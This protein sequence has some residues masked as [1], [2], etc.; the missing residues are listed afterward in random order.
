MSQNHLS[1]FFEPQGVVLVG[2]RRSMGF[3]YGIPLYLQKQ[4]WGDRLHLVNPLG[5][6]LHGLSVYKRVQDVPDPVDLAI[7]I[8]P[9]KIVPQ[10]M[11]EIGDRGITHV[12]I[13]TAGFGEIGEAGK[14]LQ[15]N[16]K[17]IA[18]RRG[19]R[20]IGPNCVGVVNTANRFASVELLDESLTPGHLGI[21]AQSGVFGNILLDQIPFYDLSISKAVTLGNRLDVDE[22][23][24]LQYLKSDSLT[25]VIMLYLEG[26]ADGRRFK[27]VLAE[28]T[29]AKPVL[30]LKSGRT[31]IGRQATA[32]HTGSLS[33]EDALYSALFQQTGAVRAQSLSQLIDLARVF[34]SQP[35]PSGNR[36][37]IITTSGSLGA[38]A[39]DMAESGGLIVPP[40]SP[41]TVSKANSVAPE[42]MNVLNPLDLGP[43]G[44]FP[45]L[46]PMLLNDPGLDMVLAIVSIPFVPVKSLRAIGMGMKHWFGELE[47][48]R[49]QVPDKPMVVAAVGH[50]EMVEEIK[51]LSGTSTPVFTTPEPAVQALAALW[52][53]EARRKRLSEESVMSRQ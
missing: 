10:V 38:L 51:A 29:A 3:G 13:E 9:A 28:V 34:I 21:I 31:R 7:V 43:S 4:G 23:E 16:I 39:A 17:G 47:A 20:V 33:G 46:L 30:I 44:N 18:S 50:P 19:M 25:K 8:V 49:N 48:I 42:W 53:Y 45:H 35:K 40:L 52:N 6:E 5:G 22:T 14:R 12:I 24:I 11:E 32:S 41:T 36:L 27:E 26:A 37:G 1:P 15:K 2:A